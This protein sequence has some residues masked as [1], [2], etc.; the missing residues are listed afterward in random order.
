MSSAGWVP[1]LVHLSVSPACCTT[2]VKTMSLITFGLCS[3]V[4][5]KTLNLLARIPNTFF[6]NPPASR[7][8]VVCYFLFPCELSF[9]VGFH[10]PRNQGESVI[11]LQEVVQILSS[12]PQG[13]GVEAPRCNSRFF[14]STCCG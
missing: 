3:V 14:S 8:S 6:H 5:S 1:C 10:K 9:V 13:S 7:D 2:L 12:L 11:T 4:P